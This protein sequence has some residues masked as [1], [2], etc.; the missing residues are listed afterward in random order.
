MNE[1]EFQEIISDIISKGIKQLKQNYNITHLTQLYG[2]II[3]SSIELK[4]ETILIQ[5]QFIEGNETTINI[6]NWIK[7]SNGLAIVEA[8]ITQL[9]K[10]YNLI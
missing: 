3:N 4:N 6:F 2:I 7:P 1:N 10:E 9:K 8:N 5:T